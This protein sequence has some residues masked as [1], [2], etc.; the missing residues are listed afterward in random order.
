MSSS[1]DVYTTTLK[2]WF[3]VVKKQ[4]KNKGGIWKSS[5][6]AKCVEGEP[7]CGQVMNVNLPELWRKKDENKNDQRRCDKN[8]SL[9]NDI[10]FYARGAKNN[11]LIYLIPLAFLVVRH[12]VKRSINRMGLRQ[13]VQGALRNAIEL[14]WCQAIA[15]LMSCFSHGLD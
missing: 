13:V 12:R 1:S 11:S 10:D 5:E 6:R 7:S 2:I 3:S 15:V 9:S 4:T 8:T 14:K